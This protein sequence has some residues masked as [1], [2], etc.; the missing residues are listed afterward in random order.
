LGGI[1]GAGRLRAEIGSRSAGPYLVTVTSDAAPHCAAATVTWGASDG[2]LTVTPVP[3]TWAQTAGLRSVS[4]LWP[5]EPGGYSLIV[6]GTGAHH[7]AA[8]GPALTVTVTRAV[9]H[10]RGTAPAG[11]SSPCGSDCLPLIG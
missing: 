11:S 8:D 7:Q 6:D 4:L 10:R 9:L 5:A 2:E 1:T 3:R